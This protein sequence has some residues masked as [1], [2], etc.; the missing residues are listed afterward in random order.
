MGIEGLPKQESEN[1][2]SVELLPE[3]HLRQLADEFSQMDEAFQ[4][5][6]TYDA[7]RQ[8]AEVYKSY[9]RQHPNVTLRKTSSDIS[10]LKV[11]G[12]DWYA[13]FGYRTNE[14]EKTANATVEVTRK[15]DE[16]V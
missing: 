1:N 3:E 16:E 2:D 6:K 14:E 11:D 9:I 8:I 12:S 10:Y 15:Q 7:A 13:L 4:H 5:A